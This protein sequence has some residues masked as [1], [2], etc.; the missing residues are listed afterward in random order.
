[1]KKLLAMVLALVMTLS[2]AVSANALKADEKINDNYAE[3]VA[4]LD[5]MGVFKG[6][7]DGSFK[8]ENK[9]TRAEVATIIYRIY[10]QDLAK[11]DKSGLYASYNKFSDMAGAG[12]AAGYIGY[13]ANA[14]FVK[15]YPDGTFKPSGN[16]TG[17]EV[18]TMIL[19]AIGYDKNGEFTGADWALNVAKYA[20]QAGVLK[21]VKGVDLNAPATR[22][23]VA[24]LLFRAIAKAPMVTYTA[25]FGYQTVSFSGSKNDSKLFKDNETLGHKNFDLTPNATNGTYGRPATK[26]TYDCGDKS[27]TVYDKPVA[28][29]T[30]A[31]SAC[32]LCK[33]L[34]EKKEATAVEQWID[35]VK[36][37]DSAKKAVSATYKATD[38]KTETG[39]QG[40]LTEVYANGDDY[41]VVYINTYL[42]KVTKVIEEVKDKNDHVKV[43]ASVNVDV[44]GTEVDKNGDVTTK[45]VTDNFETTGF[46][47]NDYVLVTYDAGDIASMEAAKGEVAKLT[48]LKG[49]KVNTKTT[50]DVQDI[51]AIAYDDVKVAEKASMNPLYDQKSTSTIKMGDTYTFYYDS[52]GNVIGVGDY[53]YDADYVVVDRMWAD[54]ADGNGTVY[55]NLVNVSDASVI[56]K[57][58]VDVV[59][60]ANGTEDN[61][62]VS[63]I[64]DDNGHFYE[65][66]MTYTVNKDGEYELR[67]TGKKVQDTKDKDVLCTY[68]ASDDKYTIN[69]NQAGKQNIYMDKDTEIL[70]QYTETPDAKY[71]AYTID[72][73]PNSFWGYVEY[74]V[75]S[76]GRADVVYVRG[77][78]QTFSY[79]FIAST[80]YETREN[81]DKSVTLTL[82]DAYYLNEDGSLG[83][84]VL[85][86]TSNSE[87]VVIDQTQGNNTL[88]SSKI[89]K[90]GL[91][92]LYTLGENDQLL[93]YVAPETLEA[94][95]EYSGKVVTGLYNNSKFFSVDDVKN[96]AWVGNF[97]KY[98]TQGNPQ[99]T[100]LEQVEKNSEL[101]DLNAGDY[102]YVQL[103]TDGKDI[104]ALHKV[105]FEVSVKIGDADAKYGYEEYI[106]QKFVEFT[107]D[108]A[109]GETITASMAGTSSALTVSEPKD[110]KVTISYNGNVTGDITVNATSA[111]YKIDAWTTL[112]GSNPSG[113]VQIVVCKTE[114]GADHWLTQAELMALGLSADDF[115]LT[116][117]GTKY[118]P[119]APS[120]GTATVRY[121]TYDNTVGGVAALNGA[122]F[123]K[124]HFN[125]ND[126]AAGS[127]ISIAKLN[128]T[129]SIVVG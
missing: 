90:A 16:V 6:Y 29:Y 111:T 1:M 14:E 83:A 28:T 22:E 86:L 11:N 33:D 103:S 75:G 69:V 125:V 12:W 72:N 49:N 102:V 41:T 58:V 31:V 48:G 119:V 53:A 88:G 95:T 45:V 57:V 7:E 30:E 117:N 59:Y 61:Y 99:A 121:M 101:A 129:H 27:T 128:A 35:G 23:L 55:A 93:K 91:Y 82:K 3:A 37:V 116:T 5:G 80:D 98:G 60:L 112:S 34:S 96:F 32:D 115:V 64:A 120:D 114:N 118:S 62:R 20:E 21:N 51:L 39:A 2:L 67:D 15:G 74:V 97:V 43:D 107:V 113:N 24:E 13:C 126:L 94:V 81:A 19:R 17:Y 63:A 87:N 25:A 78:E 40:Q 66:L 85:K 100:E 8:P 46:A 18:L 123:F 42:A 105:S 124:V 9:I 65:N 56:S 109:D 38:T 47:K 44:Y 73:L 52:Y 36:V 70:F 106:G 92:Q 68:D 108:C 84:K 79:V 110:G 89:N 104:V 77:A 26:W 54:H 4:V 122:G 71:E 10:T 127:T 76:D 50:S